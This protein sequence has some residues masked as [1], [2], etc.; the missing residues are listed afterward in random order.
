MLRSVDCQLVTDISGQP[1]SPIF[2]LECLTIEDGTD[3][4]SQNVGNEL[5]INAA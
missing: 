1:I 5:P 4:L 2:Y 3:S